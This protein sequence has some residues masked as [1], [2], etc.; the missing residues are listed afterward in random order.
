[1]GKK[2]IKLTESD[3]YNMV[4]NVLSEQTIY[5]SHDKSYD[6]KVVDGKWM[7]TKKGQNKWFSLEKYPTTIEKLDKRYPDARNQNEP[8][9]GTPK[10]LEYYT[11]FL[12]QEQG[13]SF[14]QYINKKF[15]SIAKKYDLDITGSH[16]N[17]YIKKVAK[18]NLIATKELYGDRIKKGEKLPAYMYWRNFLAY[19]LEEKNSLSNKFKSFVGGIIGDDY[20]PTKGHFVIPFV[21]PEYEPKVDKKS[22]LDKWL[23]PITKFIFG[24]DKKDSYGKLGHAGIATISPDGSTNIYEFGRYTGAKSGFGITKSKKLG[25]IA[26]IEEDGSV[27]NFSSLCSKIK[28]KTEGQGP[29]QKMDCRLVPVVDVEKG[30]SQANQTTSKPYEA[31]DMDSTDNDSN[32]GTYTIEIAKAAGVPLGK[33]CLPNPT[34]I[35]KQFDGYSVESTVV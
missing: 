15:P 25:K 5:D 33:Y 34:A 13:N 4:Q 9:D 20:K 35:I 30:I 31:F 21:F 26:K 27:S 2:V 28:S 11:E 16:N 32:C 12:N 6:Y 29:T 17:S 1:M 24:G 8:K 3:L 22:E 10:K 19:A 18:L 7:A 23:I 14:R